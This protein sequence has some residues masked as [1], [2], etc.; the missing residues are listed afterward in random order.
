MRILQLINRVPWPLTDGGAIGYYNAIQAYH[1][2]GCD[3]TVIALNT[4]KHYVSQLPE[5]LTQIATWH[6][7]DVDNKVKLW[8]AFL[9]LFSKTSY[10]VNRFISSECEKKLHSI[11]STQSFDVVVFESLFMMPYVDCV[12]N[13]SNA[14]RVLRQYNVEHLIWHKLAT[15]ETRILKK[16]YLTLLAKRLFSYEQSAL[17]KADVL[18][19]LSEEDKSQLMA[20]GCSKPIHVSPLGVSV[21]TPPS[22]QQLEEGSIFHLGSMDWQPNIEA[23]EWF[24]QNVWPVVQKRHPGSS[25]HMAGKN[26][27]DSFKQ[28][29]TEQFEVL[30]RVDDAV[31]FMMTK[32]IMVVPLFSGSGIRVKILE[33]MAIGKAIVATSLGAQGIDCEHGKNILIAN[34]VDEFCQCIGQL[35]NNPV[36]CAALGNEARKL[37]AEKYSNTKITADV[38]SFYKQQR[39]QKA[40]GYF[41]YLN[42]GKRNHYEEKQST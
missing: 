3:I 5:A 25:F 2:A 1:N 29:E 39:A 21:L 26:M 36:L 34:T 41:D 4:T 38:L 17:N 40:D 22:S 10:H 35:L 18:C 32:Q 7:I 15:S 31:S 6:T 13:N 20:M 23:M 12:T 24:A 11:L 42:D 27:P 33:G 30:G 37:V 28:Y 9:N 16:W 19:V 14:L 8:P